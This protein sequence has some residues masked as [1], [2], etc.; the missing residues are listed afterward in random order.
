ML[1]LIVGSLPGGNVVP[2]SRE[3]GHLARVA[4]PSVVSLWVMDQRGSPRAFGGAS[5]RESHGGCPAYSALDLPRSLLAPSLACL[6]PLR[7]LS[8]LAVLTRSCSVPT[9]DDLASCVKGVSMVPG[10]RNLGIA[11]S[12]RDWTLA[13]ATRPGRTRAPSRLLDERQGHTRAHRSALQNRE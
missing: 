5:R 7:L 6:A 4:V 12:S 8:C 13:W 1:S 10:G 2:R 11:V 9:E 3:R